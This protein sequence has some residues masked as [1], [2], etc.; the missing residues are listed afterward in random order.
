M[1]QLCDSR[2]LKRNIGEKWVKYIFN[3]NIENSKRSSYHLQRSLT[4]RQHPSKH[5]ELHFSLY[6]IYSSYHINKDIFEVPLQAVRFC[7]ESKKCFF[8]LELLLFFFY[9]LSQVFFYLFFFLIYKI[10]LSSYRNDFLTYSENNFCRLSF[11]LLECE[12]NASVEI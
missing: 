9:T 12:L 3:K 4:H 2:V 5:F 10:I 8:F 1:T 6:E 7:L 11:M